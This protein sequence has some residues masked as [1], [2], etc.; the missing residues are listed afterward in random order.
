MSFYSALCKQYS[1]LFRFKSKFFV[2]KV[3][4]HD[5]A[6][7]VQ[8]IVESLAFAQKLGRKD[9]VLIPVLFA[10]TCRIAYGNG[11]FDDYAGIGFYRQRVLYHAL[12]RRGIEVVGFGVVIGGRGYCY[13]VGVFIKLFAVR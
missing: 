7:G 1:K 4:S 8:I 11:R 3:A 10:Y 12:H 2:R 5:Y 6:R 9:Y 13:I